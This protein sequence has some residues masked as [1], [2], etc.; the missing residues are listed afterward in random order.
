[1]PKAVCIET[2]EE[3]ELT[4]L[5]NMCR[6]ANNMLLEVTREV[7]RMREEERK[8]NH[9]VLL[10]TPEEARIAEMMRL[11]AEDGKVVFQHCPPVRQEY[12]FP[13]EE[14]E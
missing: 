6:T 13:D 3:R 5:L 1:M 14:D 2:Q 11:Q 12:S 10:Y 7:M 4:N 8:R 9:P